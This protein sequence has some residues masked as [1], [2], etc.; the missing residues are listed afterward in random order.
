MQTRTLVG[1]EA[2]TGGK[3]GWLRDPAMKGRPRVDKWASQRWAC[4]QHDWKLTTRVITWY[5][6]ALAGALSPQ[7][8]RRLGKLTVGTGPRQRQRGAGGLAGPSQRYIPISIQTCAPSR[9]KRE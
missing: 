2:A 1:L 3:R 7:K 4:C 6:Q 9:A 5:G 8:P